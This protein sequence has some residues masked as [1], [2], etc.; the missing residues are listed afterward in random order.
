M[1][2]LLTVLILCS[3]ASWGQAPQPFANSDWSLPPGYTG[4]TFS[5]SYHYPTTLPPPPGNGY[6]WTRALH[7]KPMSP[8]NALDY[9]QALKNYVTPSMRKLLYDY[10]NWDADREKWYDLPWISSMRDP[11]H[12]TYQGL[13][14]DPTVFPLSQMTQSGMTT[15]VLVYYNDVAGYTLGRVWGNTALTPKLKYAQFPEGSVVIKVAMTTALSDSW[16]PMEGSIQWCLYPPVLDANRNPTPP[17]QVMKVALMQFDI[18]VKDSVAA[19]KTGWVFTTLVYDKHAPGNDV[20][21]KMIPMGATWGNDPDILSVY[22]PNAILQ[23]SILNP[24]TPL[25]AT[26]TLGY[27][28][29]LSGP[30]DG[31]ISQD[32]IV[33]G[34]YVARLRAV[35]CLGCHGSAQWPMKPTMM[36]PTL[37]P[38][39]PHVDPMAT[40]TAF[41][42]PGSKE[43]NQW[44][45]DRPGNVPQNPQAGAV[46]LDSKLKAVAMD[47]DM[48]MTIKALPAWWNWKKQQPSALVTDGLTDITLDATNL[49]LSMPQSFQDAISH[50]ASVGTNGRPLKPIAPKQ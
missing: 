5:L 41:Y 45:Q 11:I 21:D 29:R 37:N 31:S 1:R 6:P 33:D 35:G 46:A 30:N 39:D 50:P 40:P 4:P 38:P 44:F 14:F 10:A 23:E 25:Y 32:N 43:W 12:G 20:W 9:V 15:H 19:P 17:T 13:Q 49:L 34:K 28:G 26:E 2:P 3:V 22:T 47:Y 42:R 24:L 36:E 8:D 18:I 16:S 48:N 7:G 27:G